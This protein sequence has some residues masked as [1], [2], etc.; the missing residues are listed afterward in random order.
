MKASIISLIIIAGLVSCN[1]PSRKARMPNPELDFD[2]SSLQQDITPVRTVSGQVLYM[3]V[4]SNV[5]YQIDTVL[6][7]MSAFVAVHNTD[8][9]SKIYLT[10]VLYFNQQGKLVDD[11][12]KGEK[13]ELNPL[14]TKDF[15]IPYEDKS[16]TGANFLIEWVS[17][18]LVNEPLIESVTLS[19]KP[20]NTV[21]VLSKGKVISERH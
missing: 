11:F 19:L 21:A 4:Y 15:Y 16:G 18:S 5:P 2:I 3:P 20:N 8:L 13:L 10:K 17:D 9:S 1:N 14:S 6:F 7:D 12:L